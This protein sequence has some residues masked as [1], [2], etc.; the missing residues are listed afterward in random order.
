M[1]YC[2][3]F[4]AA[5]AGACDVEPAALADPSRVR[6]L[7]QARG[8]WLIARD[9]GAAHMSALAARF[10]RDLSSYSRAVRRV[11]ENLATDGSLQKRVEAVHNAIM[12]A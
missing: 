12:Q 2:I 9:T 4:I 6:G 11:K 8:D 1:H 7:S 3:K 5:V 10:G